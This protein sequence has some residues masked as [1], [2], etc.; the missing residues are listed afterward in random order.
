MKSSDLFCRSTVAIAVTLACAPAF[1]QTNA[2]ADAYPERTVRIVVPFSPGTSADSIAR[3]A[4]DELSKRLGKSFV[5]ENRPGASAMIGTGYA[6]SAA[7]DGYTLM[8]GM[9]TTV[10]TPAFR[11]T[12]YDPVESFTPIGQIAESPQVIVV[13]MDTPASNIQ[14]LAAYLRKLGDDA[15]YASPGIATTAHL[16]TTVLQNLMGTNMRH[17]PAGG[18]GPAIMDVVQGSVNLI[19]APVEAVRPHILS[20][21]LKAIAQTGTTR[22]ALLPDV[23]TVD[24]SGYPGFNLALWVG[25]YGPANVPRPIVEKLNKTLNDAFNDP[26]TRK[27]LEEGGFTILTGTPEDFDKLTRS[28]FARWKEVIQT[29]NISPE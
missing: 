12:P 10:V 15:S 27:N 9:T 11:K 28:E 23:P 8:V 29:N 2:N 17:I 16:Y 1:S 7:P 19:I 6:A 21:K 3:R 20:G 25:L 24:E 22:A 26:V 4:G 14:E 18:L 5:V 13:S